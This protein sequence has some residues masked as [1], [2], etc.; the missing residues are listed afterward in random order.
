M[1]MRPLSMGLA[2][3]GH[4]EAVGGMV[5]AERLS[6]LPLERRVEAAL[7]RR[8]AGAERRLVLLGEEGEEA[9]EDL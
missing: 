4:L 3:G 7:V 2:A 5:P 1:G 8:H 6:E 9:A